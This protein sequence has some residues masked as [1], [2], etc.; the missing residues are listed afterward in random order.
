MHL[1]QPELPNWFVAAFA[2]QVGQASWA[3]SKQG[4]VESAKFA[5]NPGLERTWPVEG[6]F[7][8]PLE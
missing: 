6:F 7:R 5:G 2:N 8:M 1:R 3:R 4:E